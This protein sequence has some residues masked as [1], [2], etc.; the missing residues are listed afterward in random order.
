METIF[1]D[2]DC[3]NFGKGQSVIIHK[4]NG[5]QLVD[6]MVDVTVHWIVDTSSVP[7]EMLNVQEVVVCKNDEAPKG[8]KYFLASVDCDVDGGDGEYVPGK[9]LPVAETLSQNPVHEGITSDHEL[10]NDVSIHIDAVIIAAPISSNKLKKIQQSTVCDLEL[11][12]VMGYVRMARLCEGGKT[13]ARPSYH[14]RGELSCYSDL[15][16]NG[17][18]IVIPTSVRKYV[19]DTIHAGHQGVT[20]CVERANISVCWPEITAEIKKL[21]AACTDCQINQTSQRKEPLITTT[22]PEKPWERVDYYSRYIEILHLTTT[23][24]KS[25]ILKLKST[26]ARFGI[27]EQ[28]IS[29]NRPQ[30]SS[31]EFID[32]IHMD[33]GY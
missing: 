1:Q 23:D 28:I 7:P 14:K 6:F 11:Q 25:V 29:D 31:E 22:L 19:L 21:I 32:F 9:E 3:D 5:N 12:T 26:F 4:D 20:K 30:F 10:E 8:D 17:Q 16:T 33:P 27:P 2:K 15:L 18:C 13:I 24:T